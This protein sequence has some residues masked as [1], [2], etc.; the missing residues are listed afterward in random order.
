[1][2][3]PKFNLFVDQYGTKFYARTLKELCEQI[4]GKVSKMYH[5]STDGTVYHVGYVIGQH[6]LNGYITYRGKV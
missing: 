2:K 4:P 3:P 6:W 1:M 5:E